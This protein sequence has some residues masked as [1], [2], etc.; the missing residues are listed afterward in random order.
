MIGRERALA[1]ELL[2]DGSTA[3]SWAAEVQD[4]EMLR[5]LLAAKA[6]PDAARNPAAAPLMLACEHGD[7][8]FERLG[9]LV[10]TEQELRQVQTQRVVVGRRLDAGP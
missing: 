5:L 10:R 9:W 4:P 7:A 8:M 1:N 2:P 3:L 6:R